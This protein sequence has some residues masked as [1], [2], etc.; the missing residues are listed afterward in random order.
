MSADTVYVGIDIAKATLAVRLLSQDLTY[1]NTPA[2]HGALRV[3]LHQ[4]A[5]PV[6][7]IC[8]ATGGYERALVASLHAAGIALSVVNP[9][10]A[11]DYARAR[12]LLSKTDKI[13]A[14]V[15]ADYGQRLQLAANAAPTTAQLELAALVAA[16]QDLVELIGAEK[17][18][19]EHLT[20]PLLRRHHQ[21]RLRQLEKQRTALD[22]QIT[23]RINADA[24]LAAK[25][26][27]LQQVNGVGPV[28]AMTVLA[29]MPELGHLSDTQAAALAGVAPFARDSG[30]YKGQRHI[31]GGR[32]AVRRVLYMAALSASIHNRILSAHYRHL[33]SRGKLHKVA[34]TA[35]MRKL[36]ILLN[37]LLARPS[38]SLAS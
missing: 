10:Q 1:P 31:S 18:R 27:R 29:L 26:A 5:R 35:L 12:G 34:L 24:V 33:L 20:V 36:I 38:F 28:L 4:L 23:A 6:Q 8:E 25:S 9:R 2:G 30:L 17:G 15:L 16:R 32:P 11:R 21:A 3:A 13:D 14:V 22:R 19:A 37:R 7:V